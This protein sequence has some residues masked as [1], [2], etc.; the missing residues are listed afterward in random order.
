MS[1][2][3]QLVDRVKSIASKSTDDKLKLACY[4]LCAVYLD[5]VKVNLNL[6]RYV[7]DNEKEKERG[8]F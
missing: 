7:H 4:E 3:Q 5:T 2:P 1:L 8:L 6:E